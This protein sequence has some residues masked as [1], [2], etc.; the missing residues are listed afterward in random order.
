MALWIQVEQSLGRHRKT[1]QA[2][3]L[4][5]IDRSRLVGH[6]V[7]LWCWGVDNAELSTGLLRGCTPEQIAAGAEWPVKDARRFVDA[8]LHCGGS[9]P[10]FL[11]SSADGLVIHDWNAH[12]GG[13][14][15]SRENKKDRNRR[16]QAASRER[17]RLRRD[18]VSDVSDLRKRPSVPERT[19]PDRNGTDLPPLPPHDVSADALLTNGAAAR[20]KTPPDPACCPDFAR[21]G[22]EHWAYCPNAPQEAVAS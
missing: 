16:A 5:K 18:D 4:L 2:C 10:G 20:T 14:L 6:L 22:A 13:L 1:M 3:T 9:G 11:E 7:A 21:T 19:G 17:Q 8:L 15:V 12:T